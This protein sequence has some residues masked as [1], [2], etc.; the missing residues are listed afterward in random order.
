M[1]AG[2]TVTV[3]PPVAVVPAP[4]VV[5]VAPPPVVEDS[6]A[7]AVVVAP[8]APVVAVP[9]SYV[10]DGVEFVGFVGPRFFY[11]GPGHVWLGCDPARLNRFHH[12]ESY[13][14]DWRQH[15]IRN[16]SYRRDA[17]GNFH[18]MRPRQGAPQRARANVHENNHPTGQNVANRERTEVHENN[19]P[20]GQGEPQRERTEVHENNH[21]VGQ[22]VAEKEKTNV[23][24]NVQHRQAPGQKPVPKKNDEHH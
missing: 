16:V 15:T 24:R 8:P 2:C 23:P 9:D 13:H 19:R 21:P 7:P 18:P 4:A 10:W 14:P 20:A 11:L 5:D 3:S 12:W 22:R 17:H 1:V 6:P